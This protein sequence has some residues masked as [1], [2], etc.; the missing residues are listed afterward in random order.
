LVKPS[1]YFIPIAQAISSR[2]AT[3]RKTHAVA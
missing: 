3:T 1:E 2:P